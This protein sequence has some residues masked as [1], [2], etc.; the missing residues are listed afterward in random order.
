MKPIVL[1]YCLSPG[2]RNQLS[3]VDLQRASVEDLRYRFFLGDVF[4]KIGSTDFSAPWGWVP[5]LDFAIGLLYT[6][7]TLADSAQVQFEFTESEATLA[8]ERIG[9]QIQIVASY[10][11]DSVLILYE[12][13]QQAVERF[14]RKVLSDLES[15]DPTL[16]AA[17]SFQSLQ[18][19]VGWQPS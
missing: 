1:D 12:Q 8:F 14:A 10:S 2:W 6:V 7:R 5:V 16:S 19:V 17:R 9:E 4:F 13:L 15:Q 11:T 3:S 18:Q